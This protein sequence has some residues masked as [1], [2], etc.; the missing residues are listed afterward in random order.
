MDD[1]PDTLILRAARKFPT[2]HGLIE[3]SRP[4]RLDDYQE[5]LAGTRFYWSRV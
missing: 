2:V 1:L 3:P 4:M 5:A